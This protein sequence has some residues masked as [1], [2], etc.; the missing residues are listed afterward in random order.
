MNWLKLY[1]RDNHYTRLV[2]KYEVKKY[3]AG[4]IWEKYI[5]PTLWVYNNFDDIDFDEL[6]N[7]FVI[8][9]THDSGGVIIVKDKKIFDKSEAKEKINRLLKV[10]YF[11]PARERPY[12][13]VKPRIIV[14]K[15]VKDDM[16]DDL[17]DYKFM[18]F[19][20]IPKYVYITVKN[21]N[22]FENWYDMDFNKVDIFHGYPQSKIDFEKPRLFEEMKDIAK[23]LSQ[24]IPFVRIDL[25]YVNNKILFWEMTFYDRA[26]LWRFKPKERDRKLWDLIKLPK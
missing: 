15:Y 6:P 14:E 7:Q 16:I 22:I 1:N 17:R 8:K 25:H 10:N 23:K 20:W 9:C 5:I 12:K 18:C 13:N 4:I 21:D 24:G 26:W 19:N 11:Y 3:V 2:D